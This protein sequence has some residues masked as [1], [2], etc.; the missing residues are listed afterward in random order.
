MPP[1]HGRVEQMCG[2]SREVL[3]HVSSGRARTAV[4]GRSAPAILLHILAPFGQS[5][6]H[7]RRTT[8]GESGTD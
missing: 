5:K 8:V 4:P 2:H 7:L 1:G 6:S 3:L